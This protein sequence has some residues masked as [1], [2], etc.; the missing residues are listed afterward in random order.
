MEYADIIANLSLSLMIVRG[1]LWTRVPFL[2]MFATLSAI[3]TPVLYWSY[4]HLSKSDYFLLF[5][6]IDLI[7]IALTILTVIQLFG[8]QLR[9]ISISMGIF[10][11][12][13]ALEWYF[14]ITNRKVLRCET[15]KLEVPMNLLFILLWTFLIYRYTRNERRPNARIS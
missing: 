13:E 11:G 5:Y 15:A 14:L 6:G 4:T 1:K 9:L 3:E 8:T 10:L 2:S 7:S 12:I